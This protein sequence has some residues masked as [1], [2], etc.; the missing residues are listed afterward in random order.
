MLIAIAGSFAMAA[1]IALVGYFWERPTGLKVAVTRD[2]DDFRLMAAISHVFGK[3]HESI[4]LKLNPVNDAAAS[5]AALEAGDADL[6]VVRSDIAMPPSGQTLVI[7]HRNAAILVAPAGSALARV[8]DLRGH[9]IGIVRSAASGSGNVHLLE[10][11]LAQYDIGPDAVQTVG[12]H[13]PD[14]F[15]ALESKRVDVVMAVGVP[16]G[17]ALNDVVGAVTQAG[18]GAP[19]FIPVQEA[20]AIAQRSPS[21]ESLD[22]VHGAFGG[23]P[24][25][26]AANFDTLA[27]TVR[28]VARNSLKDS[29]ASDLTRALFADR[30]SIAQREPLAT[31]IEAPSTDKG[32]A[33]PTHPG[34]AAYLDGE[35]QT[36][37][38]K[39]SD[40]I[41][42]GAML[43]SLVGSAAAALASRFNSD[44]HIEI[45]Q[46]LA[47]LL[48]ILKAARSAQTIPE[49]DDL[50]H[51]SDEILISALA[52]RSLSGVASTQIGTLSLALEQAR[53]A[54]RDRR[55]QLRGEGR[56]AL[57]EAKNR[58]LPGE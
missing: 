19:V 56:P 7:L 17:A 8:S 12:L 2:T 52:H 3:E 55:R 48:A 26:P 40:F 41:Y 1:M 21:L 39:Y 13:S 14:V 50:E 57:I 20:G 5:A 45:E 11:I 6:A 31:R 49:L 54:I 44:T 22:I 4:R 30:L 27:V 43:L 37:F 25:K 47:R 29:V 16:G 35:E 15:A 51:E 28:L 9:R 18:K 36:F 34:T 23:D 24:P 42:I 10:T 58:A 33:L 53:L 32:S 46:M 38:E